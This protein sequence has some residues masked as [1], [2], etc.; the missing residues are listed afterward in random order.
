[1]ALLVSPLVSAVEAK[2]RPHVYTAC[3]GTCDTCKFRP[4][5]PASPVVTAAVERAP[6]RAGA[7]EA[8]A[9]SSA[10]PGATC[11]RVREPQ[12]PM[13]APNGAVGVKSCSRARS[14][15]APR[16]ARRRGGAA[17]TVII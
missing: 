4:L 5:A 16:A 17:S 6:T 10:L 1:M 15:P 14:L 3:A 12:Q 11:T 2:L 8:V 7:T 13:L 9:F